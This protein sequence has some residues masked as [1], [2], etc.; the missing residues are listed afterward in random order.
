[1]CCAKSSASTA[2]A[3]MRTVIR[4]ALARWQI[5]DV[6]FWQRQ[7]HSFRSQY[8]RYNESL[9]RSHDVTLSTAHDL[10]YQKLEDSVG[11]DL[12][13]AGGLRLTCPTYGENALGNRYRVGV[14]G[15]STVF[16]AEVPDHL[17]LP[18]QLAVALRGC[19]IQA[20]VVNFG[21]SGA[22]SRSAIDRFRR[23]ED[24][25]R[26]DLVVLYLG[27]N[28]CY[29]SYRKGIAT[30]V[31]NRTPLGVVVRIVKMLREIRKE[32]IRIVERLNSDLRTTGQSL[33]IVLQP[34][35][36]A[37]PGLPRAIVGRQTAGPAWGLF[38]G[39]RIGYF[40]LRRHLRGFENFLDLSSLPASADQPLFVDW[41]HL[42]AT[43]NL[44]VARQIAQATCSEM[45]DVAQWRDR[46]TFIQT[47]FHAPDRSARVGFVKGDEVDPFNYPLF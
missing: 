27:I 42:N 46:S 25:N 29:W 3:D 35:V 32:T 8:E 28:D 5:I 6:N 16:C 30:S 39:M 1:M 15:G 20:E 10:I 31:I 12:T 11:P 22:T 37:T 23:Y 36:P 43:G 7:P 47:T 17:T 21:V 19:G 33:M 18:S 9:K 44:L 4:K 40:S 34:S 41:A 45:R 14:L 26:F 13:I 24:G 2:P 38:L